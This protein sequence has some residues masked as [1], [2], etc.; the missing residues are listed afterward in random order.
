[1]NDETEVVDSTHTATNDYI[2]HSSRQSPIYHDTEVTQMDRT[3]KF[4][5]KA[6]FSDTTTGILRRLRFGID[7]NGSVSW[8]PKEEYNSPKPPTIYQ[9]QMEVLVPNDGYPEHIYPVK[10]VI[11]LEEWQGDQWTM[12]FN[13]N[14]GPYNARVLEDAGSG[15]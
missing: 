14:E 1:M 3:V 4:W 13:E 9:P 11:E 15:G 6:L 7:V 2:D 8:L 5:N 10:T 12:I